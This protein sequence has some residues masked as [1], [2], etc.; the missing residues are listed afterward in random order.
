MLLNV[1]MMARACRFAA[2]AAHTAVVPHLTVV[3]LLA[4]EDSIHS[5]ARASVRRCYDSVADARKNS[6][7]DDMKVSCEEST[8]KLRV[9]PVEK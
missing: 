7:Q 5:H 9:E 4:F 2:A 8:V 3:S 1:V 6:N